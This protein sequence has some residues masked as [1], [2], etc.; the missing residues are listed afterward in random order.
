MHFYLDHDE[1]LGHEM[2]LKVHFKMLKLYL[3]LVLVGSRLGWVWFGPGLV[4]VGSGFGPVSTRHGIGV[5][6]YLV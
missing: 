3:G 2:I 1:I 4:W 5:V 6:T